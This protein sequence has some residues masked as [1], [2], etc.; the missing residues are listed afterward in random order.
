MLETP[1]YTSVKMPEYG[2]L[3][4]KMADHALEIEDR[5]RRQA[6]AERIIK[7]MARQLPKQKNSQELNRKLWDHLAYIADYKLDIDYPFEVQ[8]RDEQPRPKKIP[9]PTTKIRFRHYGHLLEKAITMVGEMPE[10]ERRTRLSQQ[11]AARM[12]RHLHTW[13]G[14]G[15]TDEKV[16][17]DMELYDTK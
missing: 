8:R 6:Y 16:A 17:R 3:V 4:Q 7:V 1:K 2:R 14:D 5:S 15:A 11:V 10:S 12:K 13:K 9:Y